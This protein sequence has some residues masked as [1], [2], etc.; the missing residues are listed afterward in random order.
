MG[1]TWSKQPNAAD[2]GSCATMRRTRICRSVSTFGYGNRPRSASQSFQRWRTG[3]G[4]YNS[5]YTSTRM[6][7]SM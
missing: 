4:R 5:S 6:A 1:S 2:S 3:G 7:R